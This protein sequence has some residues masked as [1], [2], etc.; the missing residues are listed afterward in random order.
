M[1]EILNKYKRWYHHLHL[2]TDKY[3]DFVLSCDNT[4]SIPLDGNLDTDCLISY[5]DFSNK[6]CIEDGN[7]VSIYTYRDGEYSGE[8]LEDIGLTA[9]DNGFIKFDK[10]TI[11]NEEFLELLTGSTHDLFDERLRLYP[12]TGNT[13]TCTYDC[14]YNE[15]GGYYEFKG[16][17]LQGFYKMEGF[18]FEALPQYIEDAW[19]MEFV[20]RPNTS[21]STDGHTMNDK[22]PENSGIFFY[23]G[24]RAENKFANLYN[25]DIT[26]YDVR[27]GVDPDC[28][29]CDYTVKRR[30]YD[31]KIGCP[32]W[33]WFLNLYGYWDSNDRFNIPN[34]NIQRI[35]GKTVVVDDD[36]FKKDEEG[37]TY[38]VD[39]CL[40]TD[41]D[42]KT[43]NGKD[44]SKN[45]Y[46]EINTDNKY[47]IFDRT[48]N[49]FTVKTW[50]EDD[51][52]VLTGYT[53]EYATN[54]FLMMNRTKTGY[55]V[56]DLKCIEGGKDSTVITSPKY[57][58]KNDVKGN[59]F[60][61]MVNADGSIGYRYATNSCEDDWVKE[62]RSF[63]NIILNDKWSVVNV[64]F[65]V[66]GGGLNDCGKPFGER[67]MKIYIYVNGFLKFV[68]KEL[69][70]FNFRALDEEYDKQE[71]VPFNIS[72]GGGSQGLM[73]SVWL[74]Y[75]SKFP[76]ILPIEK[77]FAGSFIGDIKSFK[78]YNC[79]KEYNHIL[80][81]Y[82]FEKRIIYNG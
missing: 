78:F 12:V 47:L 33:W 74:D 71:G 66:M 30:D 40:L 62:E 36:Y 57:I 32:F 24:T 67:R 60:A 81:N 51:S 13:N 44:V 11:T 38:I 58:I 82:R 22:Y 10:Y 31:V 34:C 76:Y 2:L 35:N 50:N 42:I 19:S 28:D 17:F 72:L 64:V 26:D 53:R 4:P 37:N 21:Y 61:L 25:S 80:N 14:S 6:F 49:G 41:I 39:E 77:Y 73:E 27:E 29:T 15:E 54:L 7:V 68:S 23:M 48:K 70:E 3:W 43:S 9:M 59:S 69:P 45:G 52:I 79:F 8:T 46:F 55:T 16:G 65:K 20:I 5:I 75:Y 56:S 1:S 18:D 63:P